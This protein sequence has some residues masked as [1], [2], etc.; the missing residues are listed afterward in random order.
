MVLAT[1]VLQS[2]QG[3]QHLM[4]RTTEP[5]HRNDNMEGV[6]SHFGADVRAG[7][8]GFRA[9]LS[10]AVLLVRR[11]VG[12]TGSAARVTASKSGSTHH[13]AATLRH[14]IKVVGS[15]HFALFAVIDTLQR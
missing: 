14:I 9:G 6:C 4:N 5:E 7:R 15:S 2:P 3:V 1:N 8:E 10:T 11:I 13:S 12:V